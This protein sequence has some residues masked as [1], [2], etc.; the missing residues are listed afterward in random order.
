M[1]IPFR[2]QYRRSAMDNRF[3]CFWSLGQPSRTQHS[4][5]ETPA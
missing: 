2:E 4:D 5:S 3:R 1:A